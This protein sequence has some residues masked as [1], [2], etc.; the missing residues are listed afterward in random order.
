MEMTW[1]EMLDK[2]DKLFESA[3]AIVL[4]GDEAEPEEKENLQQ[5]L[6]DAQ[7]LKLKALQL[8]MIEEGLTPLEKAQPAPAN[9]PADPLFQ[10]ASVADGAAAIA[11]AAAQKEEPFGSFNEFV[12]AGWKMQAHN[13]PDPRL[14]WVPRDGPEGHDKAL[15]GATGASGGF[16]IPT[17]F[18]PNVQAVQ[19]EGGIVR[20]YATIIRM[21]RRQ[22]SIPVLDQTQTLGVGLPAWFGGMQF[23]W[24][25]EGQEKTETEAKWLRV[26]LVAKKLIGLTHASDELIAD[27]AISI[28]D[29]LSG[30]LG[31]AGG[32]PWMEDF[33]FLRGV[34]GGQPRG[35]IAAPVTL[36]PA[37]QT[38][39]AIGYIDCIEMLSQF[40]PS[41][42]GRW[43]VTQSA[44]ANLIQM[45]GPGGNPSYVWQPNAREGVPGYLFGMPV[46]WSEKMYQEGTRGDILLADFRYYLIGDRQSTTIESSKAPRWVFDETSWR[47]VHRVDGQPWL[48]APLTYQDQATQVSPFV[49][50]GDVAS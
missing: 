49:V 13:I 45:S 3:K 29:F 34:G 37:R 16:L 11:A 21:A 24:A 5:R 36:A 28:G 23:F 47:V 17:Q 42:R 32:I 39:G 18:L 50:L 15:S 30:P 38:A 19:A 33:A 4:K 9:V 27:S 7:A 31:F 1:Q 12:Y 35:V 43:T 2:A 6:D 25:D 41:G 46:T 8:K 22:I 20:P 14:V 44:M 40:L 10:P 26:N 48:S